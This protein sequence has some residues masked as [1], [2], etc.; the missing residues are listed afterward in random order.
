MDIDNLATRL[1]H[2]RAEGK[3]VEVAPED[4]SL[5]LEEAY[6]LQS[7]YV[8]ISGERRSGWKVGAINPPAQ[9]GLGLTEPFAGPLLADTTLASL[10]TCALVAG[11]AAIVEVEF[12]FLMGADYSHTDSSAETL[13]D[14]I[15]GVC[16]GIEVAGVRYPQSMGRPSTALVVA[17]AAANIA[18]VHGTPV[19]TWRDFDLATHQADLRINGELVDGGTGGK[20]L[21]NPINSLAWLVE[22]LKR[23]NGSLQRGDLIT[24]GTVTDMRPV[25]VG[26]EVVAD[27]GGLGEAKVNLVARA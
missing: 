16:A 5:S 13:A 18:L 17:D 24:T 2:A 11:Q 21:G 1:W 6:R 15:E 25:E 10:T 14:A 4:E 7:S 27:F 23:Q 22:F 19:R 3:D 12:V 26:D 8:K 20:V 9:E